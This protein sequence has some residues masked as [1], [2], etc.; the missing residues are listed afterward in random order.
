MAPREQKDNSP[1]HL[2]FTEPELQ[3]ALSEVGVFITEYATGRTFASDVWTS[4]GL[5]DRD[6][7]SHEGWLDLV[8]PEDRPR[9]EEATRRALSGES[10]IF[11]EMFRMRDARDEYHWIYNRGRTVGRL[12]DG[13]AAYYI[14]SDADVS[15]LKEME[16]QL[17]RDLQELETL[18]EI[19][20]VIGSSLDLQETITHILEHT[21]RLIPYDTASLQILEKDHTRVVGSFGFKNPR[22]VNQLTIPFPKKNS[23]STRAIQ[24]KHPMA[25]NNLSR[26]FPSF[27]YMKEERPIL[28]WMGIPLIRGGEVIGLL[29]LDSTTPDTYQQRHMHLAGIVADHIAIALE[30]ARLHDKTYQL[31]MSDPL[32]GLGSRHRLHIEGRLLYETARR[33]EHPLSVLM[34]DLDF[35]K[36][37]NDTHGHGVG[38]KV[39][40]RLANLWQQEMRTTDLL[41]R[42]GGE[43]FVAVLPE[44]PGSEAGALAERLRSL[45]AGLNQPELG[46]PVPISIGVAELSQDP[47]LSLD[48]L[49]SRADQALYQ[50]KN[51]GR[52]RVAIFGQNDYP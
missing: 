28:S 26:D 34:I 51:S 1:Y 52:N 5:P 16:L 17:E 18:Q 43:E 2:F 7:K 15:R 32:T 33:S 44:T 12:P 40:I 14:G 47:V 3:Q 37:V 39:L 48:T 27:T 11:D 30:N 21:R 20:R 8:H 36:Q 13:R 22:A 31:A 29:T 9:V 50:A 24:E 4:M 38:D 49:I 23:L 41:C 42:L 6:I 25:T 10:R 19:V 35:F 46:A 45:S